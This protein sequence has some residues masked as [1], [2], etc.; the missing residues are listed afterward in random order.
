MNFDYE[1]RLILK[2]VGGSYA[3]GTNI[4][5]SDTDYRGVVIP[6]KS[7]F[8]GLDRFEQHESKNPDLVYLGIRKMVFL[9]LS[10]NPNILECLYADEYLLMT[11]Y[12]TRLLEI[13]NE[14]LARNCM[15]AYMGYAQ[16]QLHRLNSRSDPVG[17][18]E[19]RA[20]LIE[21]YKFDTKYALHVFRLLKTGIEI[22]KEGV[23]R[24]RRP[25]AAF[26]LDVRNGKYTLEQVNKMAEDLIKEM[27]EAEEK[28]TLPE[29]PDY[30]RV[31][32]VVIGIT[33]DYLRE[34]G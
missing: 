2:Y 30:N 34:N 29:R 23:L 32:Q 26:L 27:R 19:K 1:S 4:E 11:S 12:G 31:N 3:Y 22:L 6:P 17:R 13:R 33:E 21:K 14:F 5:D 7:Y 28:S 20:A 25:D 8:L 18:V 10:G 9:A 24:V 16:Q 15:R